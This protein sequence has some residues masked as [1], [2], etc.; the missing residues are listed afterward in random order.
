MSIFI[1]VCFKNVPLVIKG[2]GC[3]QEYFFKHWVKF[4]W[5]ELQTYCF[6]FFELAVGFALD[7]LVAKVV[8]AKTDSFNFQNVLR[9][10]NRRKEGIG[11]ISSDHNFV[12]FL[13]ALYIDFLTT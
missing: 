3:V 12:L 1:N 7:V 11:H 2:N 5:Q 13:G 10:R 8:E 4:I 6:H 9:I